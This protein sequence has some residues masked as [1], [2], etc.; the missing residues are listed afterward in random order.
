[1][2]NIAQLHAFFKGKKEKIRS[3]TQVLWADFMNKRVMESASQLTYSTL[4]ATV[5][6]VAVIFA[7]ARGFGYNKYI[8]AWFRSALD[9]QPQVVEVI[10]GFVNSYLIHT[11]S[12]IVF[13]FGLVFML[14]TVTML[15]RNIEHVF[16]D[17]WEADTQ[18]SLTRTFTDFMAMFFMLPIMIIV[19]SGVTLWMASVSKIVRE[20]YV[21]GPLLKLS[22]DIMPTVIMTGIFSV[23]YTFMPNTRVRWRNALAPAFIATLC[24]QVLQYFYVHSQ[25]WVSGY[26]AIYGSFAALPLFMLWIQFTWIIILIGAELSYVIQN[27]DYLLFAQKVSSISQRYRFMMCAMVLSHICKRM[28]DGYKPYTTSEL[29]RLTKAHRRIVETV[30]GTLAEANLIAA[31]MTKEEDE[32]AYL[33]IESVEVMTLGKLYSHLENMHPWKCDLSL[34][35]VMHN[36]K[37]KK[38]FVLR[39]EYIDAMNEIKMYEMA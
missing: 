38:A 35:D 29:C 2:K 3:I 32:R 18:R 20:E 30:L 27:F 4:L 31:V 19:N 12:G 11:K 14:W 16:N 28:K 8:E 33:P 9:S 21:I 36:E 7:I 37:W 15:T 22:I 34:S 24:M 1:M 10:I 6:V 23:L 39:K 13:G 5:P 26:N 17:I 25:M